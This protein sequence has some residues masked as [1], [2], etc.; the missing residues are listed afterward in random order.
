MGKFKLFVYK[1]EDKTVLNNYNGI[2]IEGNDYTITGLNDNTEYIIKMRRYNEDETLLSNISKPKIVKTDSAMIENIDTSNITFNSCN[3]IC[4]NVNHANSYDIYLYNTNK[5]LINTYPIN[6]LTN[7]FSLIDLIPNTDY[8]IKIKT[9][10]NNNNSFS[11]LSNGKLFK[12]Q[13][14]ILSTPVITDMSQTTNN[15]IKIDIEPVQN[16]TDYEIY[17][18]DNDILLENFPTTTNTL[19]NTINNLESDKS[20]KVKVK[21]KYLNYVT[22]DFSNE[23]VITTLQGNSGGNNNYDTNINPALPIPYDLKKNYVSLEEVD[24]TFYL[25]DNDWLEGNNEEIE[26]GFYIFFYNEDD[27]LLF[28]TNESY[29][30]GTDFIY[31]SYTYEEQIDINGNTLGSFLPNYPYKI[32]IKSYVKD[33]INNTIEFSEYSEECY[34]NIRSSLDSLIPLT[35]FKLDVFYPRGLSSTS[36]TVV[37]DTN[38]NDNLWANNTNLEPAI[39]DYDF[40]INTKII[41]NNNIT[42]YETNNNQDKYSDFMNDIFGNYYTSGNGNY[43][44][45]DNEKIKLRMFKKITNNQTN[46]IWEGES[47]EIKFITEGYDYKLYSD[48]RID[49][50]ANNSLITSNIDGKDYLNLSNPYNQLYTPSGNNFSPFDD[51]L[52]KGDHNGEFIFFSRMNNTTGF[53]EI[54]Y[55]LSNGEKFP[56]DVKD[57]FVI[58]DPS[59]HCMTDGFIHNGFVYF[60][61]ENTSNQR[62]LFRVRFDGTDLEQITTTNNVSMACQNIHGEYDE[63]YFI[64]ENNDNIV[65]SPLEYPVSSTT[66]NQ[67]INTSNVRYISVGDDGYLY[68]SK[69]DDLSGYYAVYKMNKDGSNLEIIFNPNKHIN[70]PQVVDGLLFYTDTGNVYNSNTVYSY[71]KDLVDLNPFTNRDYETTASAKNLFLGKYKQRLSDSIPQ[72]TNIEITDKDE[73]T[74]ILND[75]ENVIET[76]ITVYYDTKEFDIFTN[77]KQIMFTYDSTDPSSTMTS[78]DGVSTII[79]KNNLIKNNSSFHIAVQQKDSITN[80]YTKKNYDFVSKAPNHMEK[81]IVIAYEDHSFFSYD[82]DMQS[83]EEFRLQNC[84]NSQ[85]NGKKPRDMIIIPNDDKV[86]LT[87]YTYFPNNQPDSFYITRMDK[88]YIQDVKH[89]DLYVKKPIMDYYNETNYN[90]FEH[91]F[92]YL[93]DYANGYYY[94]VGYNYDRTESKIYKKNEFYEF[95]HITTNNANPIDVKVFYSYS[96]NERVFYHSSNERVFYQYINNGILKTNI[97]N[98]VDGVITEIATN[99][100]N[101][102]N[103][104]IVDYETFYAIVNNVLAIFKYDLDNDTF[105]VNS[106]ITIDLGGISKAQHCFHN[107]SIYFLTLEKEFKKLSLDNISLESFTNVE[108]ESNIALLAEGVEDFAVSFGEQIASS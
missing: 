43:Y 35:N 88:G 79:L 76:F 57:R 61:K 6:K 96:S 55:T 23:L 40:H 89:N 91:Y 48:N 74:I 50:Y 58:S 60:V 54:F 95:E 9:R 2:I 78:N 71:I 42:I 106:Y 72:I 20:Y 7:T 31:L 59:A 8:V 29:E 56:E 102:K 16:A 97:I 65:S 17:V 44:I 27:D 77:R 98:K 73:I 53:R 34:V 33:I 90:G 1:N 105:N 92:N 81:N 83:E 85:Y 69:L 64:L 41:N 75:I 80:L 51:M 100:N 5:E 49:G 45:K 37:Y 94:G 70:N 66:F 11:L 108:L 25:S 26:K 52:P 63:E 62:N 24:L 103:I 32:K 39:D 46:E 82:L 86:A 36:F 22:S 15:S 93:K 4:D 87:L 67:V 38:V 14:L 10:Y 84:E 28:I 12:T 21:A 68:L 18:Y 47:S 99:Y 104:H 30:Y 107:N 3:I 101:L 19:E 13:E